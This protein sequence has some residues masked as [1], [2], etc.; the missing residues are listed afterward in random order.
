M[1]EFIYNITNRHGNTYENIDLGR[2]LVHNP[3]A[4]ADP[5]GYPGYMEASGIVKGIIRHY[6]MSTKVIGS[7]AVAMRLICERE[8]TNKQTGESHKPTEMDVIEAYAI[9]C[10]GGCE[11]EFPYE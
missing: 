9:A 2:S 3:Y 6:L 10:G 1:S 4:L 5:L 11:Y 8:F 7:Y